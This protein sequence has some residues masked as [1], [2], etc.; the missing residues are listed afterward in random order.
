MKSIVLVFL[1]LSSFVTGYAT[2]WTVTNSGFNFSPAD[3]VIQE[4]DTVVF[5]VAGIHNAVEVS[6]TDWNNNDNTP[7][8]GGFS[9]GFGG[10]TV[11][12]AKL[13]PG[14]HFYV[15]M[16]HA[17]QGM[18]GRITVQPSTSTKDH[19]LASSF[20]VYPNPTQGT[21]KIELSNTEYLENFELEL[22]DLNGNP[23]ELTTLV[24]GRDSDRNGILD[25]SGL[26]AGMYI[27]R[28]SDRF[29]SLTRKIILQ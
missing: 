11:L 26:P 27:L 8:A 17:N 14:T 16:P 4:G 7:L 9:V 20:S 13:T 22:V 29:G 18:K 3:L 23:V 28:F 15:C 10:G 5:Q 2:K 1:F 6:Q 21:V 24:R 12:P 25:L 19:P